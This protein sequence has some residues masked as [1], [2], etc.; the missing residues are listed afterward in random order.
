MA[1][2]QPATNDPLER[3]VLSNIAEY[4]WH[5]VNFVEDNGCPPW[6]VGFALRFY[7]KRHFPLYQIVWPDRGG[8][9]PGLKLPPNP[10]K[11]GNP[12]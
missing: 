5:A 10:S 12:Y 2:T 11:S 7:R 9:F 4:G 6:Y 1:N 8:V 3:I